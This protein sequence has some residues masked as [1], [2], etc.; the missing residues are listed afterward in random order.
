MKTIWILSAILFFTSVPTLIYAG[1]DEVV[2]IYN[3]RV[4]ESK[5]VAEHY[6]NA[7]HIP[8]KQIYGF[9]MTTNEVMSRDEFRPE[10]LVEER[11]DSH[12]LP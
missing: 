6:A 2:V 8:K 9:R 4:P 1:G 5:S 12:R 10:C 11:E 7:R 3:A